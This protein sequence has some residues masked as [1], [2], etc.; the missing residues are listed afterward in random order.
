MGTHGEV[1]LRAITLDVLQAVAVVVED[2][3]C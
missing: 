2:E 1:G 3:A